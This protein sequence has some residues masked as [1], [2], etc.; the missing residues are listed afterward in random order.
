M[1]QPIGTNE[2]QADVLDAFEEELNEQASE[3][4]GDIETE[5]ERKEQAKA[6]DEA[7]R[8]GAAMAVGFV[9]MGLKMWKPYIVLPDDQKA[10][11]IEKGAPVAKKYDGGMPPWLA[12]Y[13]EEVELLVVVAVAGVSVVMQIKAHEAQQA[14]Q[15]EKPDGGKQSG[16]MVHAVQS[17]KPEFF[18]S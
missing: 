10:A 7:A 17:E 2:K 9:E 16:G 3:I 11:L 12:P 5:S 1:E 15:S 18:S 13:R 8:M 14:E 4:E 6:E